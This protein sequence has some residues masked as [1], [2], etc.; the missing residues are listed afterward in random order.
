MATCASDGV[1]LWDLRKLRNF[2][3]L[4]PYEGRPAAAVAFDHSGLY[5]GVGGAG[6]LNKSGS[7]SV[8]GR[9]CLPVTPCGCRGCGAVG[10]GGFSPRLPFHV[11]PCN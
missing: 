10:P 6:A 9:V 1:K 3:S 11:L 7:W 8:G 2:K 5:L 4:A